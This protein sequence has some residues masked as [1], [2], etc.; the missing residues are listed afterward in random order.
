MDTYTSR[1]Y[2]WAAIAR[3]WARDETVRTVVLF[4]LAFALGLAGVL[5][6]IFFSGAPSPERGHI[7]LIVASFG[8]WLYL[9][10][11]GGAY[12]GP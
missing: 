1:L 2:E 5:H 11:D 10:I 3:S 12:G 7:L 4:G 8:V 6:Y 9:A